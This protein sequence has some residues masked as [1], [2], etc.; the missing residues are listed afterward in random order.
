[1]ASAAAPGRGDHRG[2]DRLGDRRDPRLRVAAHG[3]PAGPAV[4]SGLPSRH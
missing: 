1:A 4:G 2:A 3:R